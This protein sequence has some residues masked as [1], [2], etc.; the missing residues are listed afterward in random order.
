MFASSLS[1]LVSEAE[2][3]LLPLRLHPVGEGVEVGLLPR[4]LQAAGVAVVGVGGGPFTKFV[5]LHYH[6]GLVSNDTACRRESIIGAARTL[7]TTATKLTVM[8]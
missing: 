3:V 6:L 8:W 4:L 7:M 2:V 5:F 1:R